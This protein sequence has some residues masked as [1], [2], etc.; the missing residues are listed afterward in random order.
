MFKMLRIIISYKLEAI[1]VTYL[2]K[3]NS[4]W[5]LFVFVFKN[6]LF[7]INTRYIMYRDSPNGIR[8]PTPR[9]GCQALK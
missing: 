6:S 1:V 7:S 2:S 5:T 8:K 4:D 3:L 9:L